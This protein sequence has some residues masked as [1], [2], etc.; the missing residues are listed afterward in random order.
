MGKEHMTQELFAIVEKQDDRIVVCGFATRDYVHGNSIRHMAVQI[1]PVALDGAGNDC[2]VFIH[3]RSPFK[4]TSPNKLDFCGGHITFDD[5]FFPRL[6]WDAPVLLEK[7]SHHTALREA[8]EEIRCDPSIIFTEKNLY[9]FREVGAFRCDAQRDDGSI[10][11]EF[12]TAFVLGLPR[13]HKVTVWDTD[14]KGERQLEVKEK[15]FHELLKE[16]TEKPNDFA[17]GVSRILDKV[18][19]DPYMQKELHNLMMDAAKVADKEM[20]KVI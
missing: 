7:A 13:K 5:Q 20:I 16:F 6:Y 11:R 14:R 18:S 3:R 2:I 4:G 1:I 9:R 19:E 17:D 10:N 15:M 8:R 12:S